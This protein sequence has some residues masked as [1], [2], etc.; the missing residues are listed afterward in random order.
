MARHLCCAGENANKRRVA[1][2]TKWIVPTAVLALM[3][4]CPMCVAA[5]IAL[6]TGFSVSLPAA[7]WIRTGM[8]AM[9]LCVM[10][11]LSIRAGMR[12]L[13]RRRAESNK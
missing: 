9:C 2:S 5:Y 7:T 10:A 8:L 11:Y 1:G 4:K 13:E 3:P 12:A 6:A